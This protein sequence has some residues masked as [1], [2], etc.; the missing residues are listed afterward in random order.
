M[1]Y[2]AIPLSEAPGRRWAWP[3]VG[4]LVFLPPVLLGAHTVLA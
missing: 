1:G 4:V 3:V 2:M